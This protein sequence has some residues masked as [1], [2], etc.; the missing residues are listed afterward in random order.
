M[1]VAE[2]NGNWY[3]VQSQPVIIDGKKQY[4]NKW[5]PISAKTKGE[6]EDKERDF[7]KKRSQGIEIDPN[8]TVYQ[9]SEMWMEQHV[10]SPVNPLAK[11]TA[12]FYRDKLDTHIIPV[13]GA[14]KI[15]KLTIDDLDEVLNTCAKKD[16]KDT[17]LRGVYA[18]MS[19]MFNWAQSKKKI[20][21][22]DNLMEYV[23]RPV[24]AEREYTLLQKE[25]IPKFLQAVITPHKFET[26]YAQDQRY[27]YLTM[28]LME[29]TT[30]LRIDELCGIREEDIDFKNKVLYVRQQITSAG[31]NPTFD[32]VKDR[33]NKRPDKIP[34]TGFIIE[35]IKS[36]L[37]AKEEKKVEAEKKGLIWKEYGLIFTNQTGGPVDSKNLNTRTFKAALK[38]AGLPMMKF[39][40]L[41]HSVLTILAESNEDPNAIC[42]M[43]RH[44]DINFMKRTYI[45]KNVEAQ[46]GAAEKLEELVANSSPVKSLSKRKTENKI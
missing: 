42:D 37:K 32:P 10:K 3:I 16:A 13:I 17:T 41:R 20:D 19:A 43:A 7:K 38:K 27:M 46:R 5:I 4:K 45:H 40:N 18:T 15:R 21:K 6:A 2:K 1:A 25:D 31:S 8:L 34:L 30:A 23:D 14:K 44:A 12:K 39:H 24:V 11:G 26:K 35:A 22:D 33:R 28:F 29:L 9:L 36:E